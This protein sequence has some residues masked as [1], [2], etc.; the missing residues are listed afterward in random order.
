MSEKHDIVISKELQNELKRAERNKML[1]DIAKTK[2]IVFHMPNA[3]NVLFRYEF[4][5]IENFLCAKLLIISRR[6]IWESG[7]ILITF[8]TIVASACI[9]LN[10]CKC[11]DCQRLNCNVF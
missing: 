4:P 1:V 3:R 11:N 8:S 5:G 9:Y 7:G 2:E 10:N 6:Q